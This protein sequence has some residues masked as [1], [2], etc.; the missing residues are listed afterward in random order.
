MCAFM[1]ILVLKAVQ[2]V[3]ARSLITREFLGDQAL[4]VRVEDGLAQLFDRRQEGELCLP[5]SVRAELRD[6]EGI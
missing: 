2:A 5:C 3:M 1:L 4:V 6:G